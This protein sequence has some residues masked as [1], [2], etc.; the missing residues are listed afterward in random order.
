MLFCMPTF[1]CMV[2]IVSCMIQFLKF[3]HMAQ[4]S[5]KS[6]ARAQP[7]CV[8]RPNQY[9]HM[10]MRASIPTKPCATKIR[11]A[12]SSE[13]CTKNCR[14]AHPSEPCVTNCQAARPSKNMHS[15]VR[16]S[17]TCTRRHKPPSRALVQ[18]HALGRAYV[19]NV[20]LAV[21]TSE[22]CTRPCIRPNTHT[23]LPKSP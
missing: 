9:V 10:S 17:G 21:S 8:S 23:V 22:T 13:P 1:S 14:A 5:I 19:R 2:S 3:S 11:A 15:I 12:H 16:T 6:L 4:S 7:I 18:K 20:H